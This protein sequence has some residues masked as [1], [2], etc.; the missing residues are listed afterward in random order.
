M[1]VI[2]A[3]FVSGG[4]MLGTPFA[5]ASAPVSA[6]EPDAKARRMRSTDSAVTPAAGRGS[7]GIAGVGTLPDTTR[8]SPYARRPA[9]QR[10][11]T[12]VWTEKPTPAAR[13]P[14]TIP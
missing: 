11:D 1:S 4:F 2:D 12:H 7:G 5:T 9:S 6:T 8:K 13:V 14:P 10:T 3:F